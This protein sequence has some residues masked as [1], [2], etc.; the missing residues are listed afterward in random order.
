M[1]DFKITEKP[2]S[3]EVLL[4]AYQTQLDLYAWAVSRLEP[5]AVGRT[6]ALLVNISPKS[7]QA[8]EVPLML[9]HGQVEEWASDAAGIVAGSE[10]A[11]KP[12]PLCRM[13]E[14]RPKCPEGRRAT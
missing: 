8:V 11:P 7:I 9:P 14:F 6:Q 1:I 2:K 13:C 10:G 12:G 4:E 5:R 3:V